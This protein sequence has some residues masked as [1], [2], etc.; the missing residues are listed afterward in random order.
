MIGP[1]LA[2]TNH[3]VVNA[4]ASSEPA[5]SDGDFELQAKATQV[6]F[7]Y[8]T[9]TPATT[10]AK[11]IGC[12]AADRTLDY[13]VLRLDDSGA[14][15]QPLRLRSNPLTRPEASALRERVNVLQHPGG[16]PMRLAFRNNF[17]VVGSNEKLSYLT[18][19]AGGSSGSPI[20]DDAWHVAGLH[21]GWATIEGTPVKVWG[22]EIH[23]ENYGTPIGLILAQLAAEKPEL[24]AEIVAGQE[25]L[26]SA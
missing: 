5:A 24:H 11:A 8:Y 1:R 20:C 3:H 7:D 21:R 17:V 19:T 9:G 2:I 23:Q 22:K 18:D 6:E 15:R 25:A 26:P 16:D 12:E 10:I 4:R 14:G 13:A